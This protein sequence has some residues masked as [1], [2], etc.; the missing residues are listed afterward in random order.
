MPEM[1][2]YG[3][4]ISRL[5]RL[6]KTPL[7]TLV[8][9][10]SERLIYYTSEQGVLKI[11]SSNL[12]GSD[13]KP[14]SG[15]RVTGVYRPLPSDKYVFYT[16]DVTKGKELS[17]IYIYDLEEEAEKKALEM[18]PTRVIGVSYN[19]DKVVYTGAAEDGVALFM[20]DLFGKAEKLVSKPTWMFVSSFDGRYVVGTGQFKGNPRSM[21]LFRYDV[22]SGEFLVFTPKEG[23]MNTATRIYN[24]KLIFR[25]N[26]EGRDWNYVIDVSKFDVD[27]IE[28]LPDPGV[29]GILD[30]EPATWLSTGEVSYTIRSRRGNLAVAGDELID[31]GRGTPHVVEKFNGDL[32]LTFSSFTEPPGIY[33]WRDGEL[34]K[35]HGAD[36]GQA[37]P[38]NG[39]SVELKWIKSVDELEIPTWILENK[40]VSKPGPTVIYVHGGP[41]SHVE[42]WWSMLILGLVISGFHV[43]APNFRGSTGYGTEFMKMD[44]GDPGGMDME[45][46]EAATKYAVESGLASK[47]A[48]MGY[49]YGGFMTFLSTV[50]KPDTWDAGVA[51]AGIVDWEM[52]LEM[53][54]PF[55]QYFI[56]ILFNGNRELMKDRSA[57]N[58]VEN[59]KKPLC[60]IHPQN[61]T[62]TP[63]K[64]VLKYIEKLL[65][66][67][68]TFEVHI[69][70]D[71]GH[72]VESVDDIFKILFPAI[73]F[74]KKNI[75]ED[76]E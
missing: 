35:I 45:D 57:I 9:I 17:Q 26:F 70:P 18:T 49:S 46:I 6:V 61:D 54:D 30:V 5:E 23:S 41:W 71:M 52:M 53:S 67:G 34:T 60:I 63:L 10:A 4:L 29:E 65:E 32:Y 15:E 1:T 59:L 62:R 24:G 12:D 66:L 28:P 19:D 75:A 25:S 42:D 51:G 8:G 20:G 14:V 69:I 7:Y 64:P 40:N 36:P 76:G 2:G 43:V 22:S 74:L 13:K 37:L 21:E 47:K 38:E 50:K 3:D 16:R 11:W 56:H 58:F 55:F 33:R 68:K 31:L 72:G 48:I 44:I 73:L 39:I 27:S